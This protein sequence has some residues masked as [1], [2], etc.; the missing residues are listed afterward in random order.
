MNLNHEEKKTLL[1]I[2][3]KTLEIISRVTMWC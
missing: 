1:S 3:R 2:A